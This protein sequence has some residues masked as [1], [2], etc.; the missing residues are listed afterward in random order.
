LAYRSLLARELPVAVYPLQHFMQWGTPEDLAEYETWSRT[1]RALVSPERRRVAR[2]QGVT[3][4]PMAGLGERFARAGYT[5]PKPLIPVSG[6]PMV[7]QSVLDVGTNGRAVFVLRRDMPGLESICAE[8]SA[9]LSDARFVVLPGV[10]DGQARS[11][12][13]GFEKVDADVGPVTITACDNGMLY[14]AAKLHALL[15]DPEV[16]VI[17]WV[18]RGDANAAR[19]PQMYGWV[20]TNGE[21]I[22]HVSVKQP[23]TEPKTDPVVLGTFTFRRADQF[24]Q[25]ATRM[26]ERD[27]RVNGEFYVDTLINDALELG[28]DCRI[29]EVESSTCWGT[30]NDLSTFEYWQSCFHKWPAHPYRLER[31]SRVPATARLQLEAKYQNFPVITPSVSSPDSAY[32]EGV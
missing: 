12:A 7:L 18:V 25:A 26:F 3:V 29:F 6:E 16:D 19:Q 23:L 20:A 24:T 31:D 32:P 15:A 10:T 4:V 1:F 2:G 13:L 8:L 28:M 11:V 17:V 22:T 14:D 21:R 30:P 27:A 9:R 5:S